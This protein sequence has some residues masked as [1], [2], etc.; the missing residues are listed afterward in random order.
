MKQWIALV[1]SLPTGNATARMR[2]W[3]ALKAAGAAVLRDGVY[4]LPER[5]VCRAI[6]D[7]VAADVLASGGSAL[8]MGVSPPPGI[9]FEDWFERT[10]DYAELLSEI[11]RWREAWVAGCGPE[12]VRQVRKLRKA[13]QALA[14]IDFFPG[15][16][17]RQAEAALAELESALARSLS[18]DEPNAVDAAI[19]RLDPAAYRGRTWAT[20]CRPWV[21]RLASAWLIRR[22]IDPDAQI[23]WL[24]SPADCPPAALGFDFDGAAFSHVGGRVTFEVLLAAFGIATPALERLAAVVHFLDVGGVPVPEAGG[25]ESILAGL[26]A[27]LADDDRLLAAAATVFDGLLANFEKTENKP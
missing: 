4:L 27:S 9:A 12:A 23:V 21:D 20:R 15:E 11:G 18:P 8:V 3:R 26:R 22:L 17:Q 6:L 5:E 10:G 2:A 25:V 19:P 7:G 14:A 24:A 13:G 16:A 1:V